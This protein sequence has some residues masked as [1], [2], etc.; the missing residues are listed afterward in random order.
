[1]TRPSRSDARCSAPVFSMVVVDLVQDAA[2]ARRERPVVHAWRPAGVSR[3]EALLPA[4]ALLVVAHDEIALHH[5]HLFPMVVDERLG[6]ERARLDLQQ[7]G[8]ASELVRL[9]QVGGED[10]LVEAGR[11]ARRDLPAGAQVDLHELQVL[12]GLHGLLHASALASAWCVTVPSK[13]GKFAMSA[14]VCARSGEANAA[15]IASVESN[16]SCASSSARPRF[17]GQASLHPSGVCSTT[18]RRPGQRA[19]SL[20]WCSR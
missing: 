4:L 14:R 12:L 17:T 9:V 5:V 10:L 13:G 19:S 8:A 18:R 2:A 6:G 1:M 20:T 16:S 7:A 11:I 15:C 3:R